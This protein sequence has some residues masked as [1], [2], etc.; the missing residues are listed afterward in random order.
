M[1]IDSFKISNFFL[2]ENLTIDGHQSV[3]DAIEK[4]AEHGV[5]HI[6][7]CNGG[8][9]NGIFTERD[10]LVNSARSR[11]DISEV[12]VD[13]WSTHPMRTVGLKDTIRVAID[14]FTATGARRL[15]VLNEEGKIVGV[16]TLQSIIMGVNQALRQN[17]RL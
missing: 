4:M 15:P 11:A 3:R 14:I 9:P 10:F 17:L 16:C 5:G 7:I 6:L 12:P 1:S 8:E 13:R 2:E